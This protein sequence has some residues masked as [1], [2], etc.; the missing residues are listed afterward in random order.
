MA[1][2][3]A[4]QSRIPAAPTLD[5]LTPT[6]G[7]AFLGDFRRA[8]LDHDLCLRVEIIHQ[9]RRG[10]ARAPIQGTLWAATVGEDQLLRGEI[11]DAQGRPALAFITV[12]SP[13]GARVWISRGGAPAV[14]LTEANPFIALADGLLLSPFDLQLPFTHWP[15]T[16]YLATERRRRP[17]HTFDALNLIGREPA[18]VNFAVDHVYGVLVEAICYDTRGARTRTIQVEEFSKVGAQWILAACRVRDET[19]RDSDLMRVTAAAIDCDFPRET[20]EPATLI[21]AAP[22][23]AHFQA[24]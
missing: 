1:L 20:F 8:R 17:A 23:P 22:P 7:L 4:A 16:A 10:D 24:L 5:Q 3:C 18:K 9:P 13:R 21:R 6:Q 12:K 15:A 2:G 19:T 11:L 14:E